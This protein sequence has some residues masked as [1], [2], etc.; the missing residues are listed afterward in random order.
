VGSIEMKF[1]FYEDG[2]EAHLSVMLI[3]CSFSLSEVYGTIIA[4]N[5]MLRDSDGVKRGAYSLR[6]ISVRRSP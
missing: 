1:A 4:S 3:N 2:V 5:S 6:R